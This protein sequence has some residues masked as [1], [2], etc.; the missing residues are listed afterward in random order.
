[1]S[2]DIH[3]VQTLIYNPKYCDEEIEEAIPGYKKGSYVVF[4]GAK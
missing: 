4:K 3:S 1:V 2:R